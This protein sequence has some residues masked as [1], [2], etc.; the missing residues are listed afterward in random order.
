MEINK[1]TI[2]ARLKAIG[3]DRDWFAEQLGKSRHTINNWLSTNIVIPDGMYPLIERVISEEEAIQVQRR[4]L[5]EPADHVVK[6]PFSDAD[7]RRINQAANEEGLLI[8]DWAVAALVQS[9]KATLDAD[10]NI[11]TAGSTE[12]SPKND[13]R[14]SA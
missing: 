13:Q 8:V 1:D 12:G 2:K 4:Q 11:D 14:A 6:L 9:A 3:K 7:F 10:S 5:H